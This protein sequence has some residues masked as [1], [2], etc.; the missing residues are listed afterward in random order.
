MAQTYNVPSGKKLAAGRT[1]H[2]NTLL[3]TIAAMPAGSWLKANTNLFSDVWTPTLLR[4]WCDYTGG[5]SNVA[6]II[7]AWGAMAWDHKHHRLMI[8]G[9]GHNNTAANDVYMWE[10]ET[11]QWKLAYYPSDLKYLPV[12]GAP[13]NMRNYDTI[14]TSLSTPLSAH[15]Y[16]NHHYLPNLDRFI[17]FCGGDYNT[18]GG[19]FV[20]DWNDP[21]GE[22]YLRQI[23]CYTLD[24]SLAGKG[25]VGGKTGS[26][27]HASTWTD[28][29]VLGARAWYA[30]DWF[31]DHPSRTVI[32]NYT[33]RTNGGGD[34]VTENGRDVIYQTLRRQTEK[35]LFRF[36]IV[37]NDY[38]N[39]IITKVGAYT[40][41]VSSDYG[42]AI[43][44]TKYN[45]F[46]M[47]HNSTG[48]GKLFGWDLTTAG[49]S[50][51]E[52]YVSNSDITQGPYVA[53]FTAIT[54]L[55]NFGAAF[56]PIRGA[57][58]MWD[59]GGTVWKLT[60]P[61]SAVP[62]EYWGPGW[63]IDKLCD[64]TVTTK[65]LTRS[66]IGG[67]GILGKWQYAKDLDCFVGI[68]NSDEGNVWIFKPI[69]WVDPR[70]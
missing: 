47:N 16:D 24:L 45:K 53:E 21:I 2:P 38:H 26:N 65:P 48:S 27:V 19:P 55:G 22:N 68:Q 11:Q 56:D 34:C 8:W 25:F 30:R 64:E 6:K 67:T 37:D 28:V 10:C 66:V 3:N 42:A 32:T 52:K 14:D 46:L 43:V 7:G 35:H 5:P 13:S 60:P 51:A 61:D 31:L 20:R 58:V 1:L 4:P 49:S 15:C 54:K 18:G 29:D 63:H 62:A 50:N 70:N 41:G 9:G 40:T 57:I 39:D 33:S 17:T 36:E 44:D 23:G 12:E 69:G 59:H